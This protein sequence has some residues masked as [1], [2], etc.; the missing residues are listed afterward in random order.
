MTNNEQFND[1]V[2]EKI[3]S[4]SLDLEFN[5]FKSDIWFHLDRETKKFVK[6]IRNKS[7]W[8]NHDNTEE[9]YISLLHEASVKWKVKYGEELPEEAATSYEVEQVSASSLPYDGKATLT[10]HEQ[11]LLRD[12]CNI[13]DFTIDMAWLMI[14]GLGWRPG[15]PVEETDPGWLFIWHEEQRCGAYMDITRAVL[16]MPEKPIGWKPPVVEDVLE[17]CSQARL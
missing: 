11:K 7:D 14:D 9:F 8:N 17:Q 12:S 6:V 1:V 13:G 5:I 3:N 10:E 2:N 4:L 15:S 16:N